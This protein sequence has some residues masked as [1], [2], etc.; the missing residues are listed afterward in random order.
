MIVV[1]DVVRSRGGFSDSDPEARP[2]RE[3]SSDLLSDP[4][5]LPGREPSSDI[6][7]SISDIVD[8]LS[9]Y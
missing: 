2:E 8:G 3:P 6:R 9:Y 1:I 5:I 7:S 4:E